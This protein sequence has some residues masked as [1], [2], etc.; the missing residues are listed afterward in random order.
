[1]WVILNKI[2][3]EEIAAR[4]RDYLDKR[5]I[6][7]IETIP[8]DPEIFESYLEGCPIRGRVEAEDVDELLNFL[9]P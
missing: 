2:T 1:M 5:N 3:S 8:Q 7:V 9:F 4:L 6:G